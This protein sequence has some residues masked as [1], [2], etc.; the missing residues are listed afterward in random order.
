[1]SFMIRSLVSWSPPLLMTVFATLLWSEGRGAGATVSAQV[2]PGALQCEC[3]TDPLGI[4]VETPR[5][6]WKLRA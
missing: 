6:S 3:L 1:M 2:T 4:D 5:F